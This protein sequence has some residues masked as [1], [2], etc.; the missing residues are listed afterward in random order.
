MLGQEKLGDEVVNTCYS[1]GP[2]AFYLRLTLTPYP[3]RGTHR[4]IDFPFRVM[5][6][7]RKSLNWLLWHLASDDLI[8]LVLG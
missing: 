5:G 1:P 7:P 4:T 3:E 2:N 8:L 6:S